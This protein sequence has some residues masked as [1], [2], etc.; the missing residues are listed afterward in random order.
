MRETAGD[1]G[2]DWAETERRLGRD[3]TETGERLSG[4]WAETE[5]T[6]AETR[7]TE[8]RILVGDWQTG[9]MPTSSQPG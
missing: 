3:W 2:R 6:V 1:W 5:E 7:R 4:D 9:Q 8:S